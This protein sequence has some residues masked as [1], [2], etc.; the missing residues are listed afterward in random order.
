MVST[1]SVSGEQTVKQ[2]F[3]RLFFA[4][5]SEDSGFPVCWHCSY[6]FAFNSLVFGRVHVDRIWIAVSCEFQSWL[7]ADSTCR[8]TNLGWISGDF[9]WISMFIQKLWLQEI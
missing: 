6:N 5:A 4:G 9:E 2:Y 7:L 3:F 1:S 8:G